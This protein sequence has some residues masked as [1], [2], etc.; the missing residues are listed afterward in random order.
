MAT[1]VLRDRDLLLLVA[2]YQHGLPVNVLEVLVIAAQVNI[3]NRC[4]DSHGNLVYLS[5]FPPPYADFE[6]MRRNML[7]SGNVNSFALCLLNSDVAVGLPLHLAIVAGN[8]NHVQRLAAWQ[9]QWVSTGAVSLAA[10]CGQLRI[11]QYLATLPNGAPTKDTMTYAAANGYLDI[12]QWLHSLPG[13]PYCTAEAR[14]FAVANGHLDVVEFLDEHGLEWRTTQALRYAVRNGHASVVDY[15]LSQRSELVHTRPNYIFMSIYDFETYRHAPSRNHL[16]TL[17]VLKAYH[18]SPYFE[19]SIIRDIISRGSLEELQFLCDWGVW[20]IDNGALEAVIKAQDPDCI[21]YALRRVLIDDHRWPLRNLGDDD[22]LWDLK[23]EL[24]WAPWVP[25]NGNM[26]TWAVGSN[27]MDVAACLGDLL[28]VELLHRLRLNCC[29]ASAM[30]HACARGHLDVAKWLHVHRSEGCTHDAMVLAAVGGHLSV[31][32]WLHTVRRVPCSEDALVAAA[33]C[34]DEAMLTYLATL[35]MPN[36]EVEGGLGSKL[37]VVLSDGSVVEYFRGGL[38]VDVAAARGRLNIV[39]L[40]HDH[41]ASTAA[42]DMAV[43]NNDVKV[44]QYLQ[45]HR[46]EGCTESAFKTAMNG[47]SDVLLEL[48]A[49][50]YASVVTDRGLLYTVAAKRGSVAQMEILW[51]LLPMEMTPEF[52]RQLVATAP[53]KRKLDLLQ[54]LI[55]TKV[56]FC[57]VGRERL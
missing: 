8:L 55:E 44:A 27:A 17:Q 6:Y 2:E 18:V 32:Q 19:P 41:R 20:S 34:G 7:S 14:D 36:S 54:W 39:E 40:L 53:A 4:Q 43:S 28:T 33:N 47:H 50:H 52:T 25:T 30:D 51:R 57:I 22:C 11:L 29:S 23:G 9:P 49:T 56:E 37:R 15:L 42:L 48:L 31:V 24:P 5:N 3:S 13:G 46:R 10:K 12:V 35:P 16:R 26:E 45:A 1:S 38:A 21:E